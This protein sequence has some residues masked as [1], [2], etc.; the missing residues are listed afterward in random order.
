VAVVQQGHHRQVTH[1]T[2]SNNTFNQNTIN[3]DNSKGHPTTMNTKQINNY[4]K[5]KEN[6]T[7]TINTT[8][9]Q[10]TNNKRC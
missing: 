3:K 5:Y 9:T 8:I 1:I 2:R 10:N 4:S 7:T 6:T